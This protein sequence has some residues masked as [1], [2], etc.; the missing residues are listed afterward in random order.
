MKNEPIDIA[1]EEAVMD[2]L[3]YARYKRK[4]IQSIIRKI[5]FKLGKRFAGVSIWMNLDDAIELKTILN[6][7]L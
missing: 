7:I 4:L 1:N 6:E 2:E 5:D 3:S